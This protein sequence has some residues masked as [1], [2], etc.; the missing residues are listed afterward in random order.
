MIPFLLR[1]KEIYLGTTEIRTLYKTTAAS[2][3]IE[4]AMLFTTFS[5]PSFRKMFVPFNK[6]APEITK[7]SN[8]AIKD[9]V[10]TLGRLAKDATSIEMKGR[11]ISYTI[12]HWTGPN[13][14]TYS[15]PLLPIGLTRLG[16]SALP[17]LT[18]KP[19]KEQLGERPSTMI[20]T[21]F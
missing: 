1:K 9:Q 18:S 12:N 15:I 19:S 20:L 4:E 7:V 16:L 5:K 11:E 17:S 2:F 14:Q 6:N 13:D 3:A 21:L 8:V 10:M